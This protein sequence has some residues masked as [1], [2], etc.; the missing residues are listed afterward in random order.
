MKS[1]FVYGFVAGFGLSAV[2]LTGS[3]SEQSTHDPAKKGEM[4]VI[5]RATVEPAR[6]NVSPSR[7]AENM[8]SIARLPAPQK[9]DGLLQMLWWTVTGPPR[10]PSDIKVETISG[11]GVAIISAQLFYRDGGLL[12]R[13]KVGRTGM[14]IDGGHLDVLLL[15]QDR[16]LISSRKIE[17][18]LQDLPSNV[19]GSQG[20]ASYATTINPTPPELAIIVVRSHSVPLT[21]CNL[22]S[23]AARN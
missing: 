19:R 8:R 10:W 17:H 15:D 23:D 14:T 11:W 20:R 6:R 5:G 12:L 9:P 7:I 22:V 13:G 2:A 21:R 4:V 16:Q 18:F 1:N 3:A